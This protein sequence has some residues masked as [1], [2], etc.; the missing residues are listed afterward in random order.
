VLVIELI[1][2][3]LDEWQELTKDLVLGTSHMWRFART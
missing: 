2:W 1:S 3:V